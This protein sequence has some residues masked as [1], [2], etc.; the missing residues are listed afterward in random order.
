MNKSL[1]C[2]AAVTVKVTLPK[3]IIAEIA[4]GDRSVSFIAII[5]YVEE[6]YNDKVVKESNATVSPFALNLAPIVMSCFAKAK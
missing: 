6:E 4:R 2:L 3:L 5:I 1:V